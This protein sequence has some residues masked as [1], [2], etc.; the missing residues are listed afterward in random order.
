MNDNSDHSAVPGKASEFEV[1]TVNL[2]LGIVWLHSAQVK[3]MCIVLIEDKVF[4]LKYY[5]L[6]LY[7]IGY[8]IYIM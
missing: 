1:E 4:S 8:I 3:V 2:C 5:T 7:Y 6:Y